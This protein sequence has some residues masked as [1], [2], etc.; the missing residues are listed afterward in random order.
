MSAW[1]GAAVLYGKKYEIGPFIGN[2]YRQNVEDMEFNKNLKRREC[3][4]SIC[5]MYA[6][7]HIKSQI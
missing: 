5:Q 3:V 1:Y 2:I 4:S 6:V 7:H